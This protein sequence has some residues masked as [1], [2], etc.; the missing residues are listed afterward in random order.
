MKE[1]AEIISVRFLPLSGEFEA[2][3]AVR[4]S[5]GFE[6]GQIVAASK[7]LAR[8]VEMISPARPTNL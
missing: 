1:T 5:D 7:S 4:N 2:T 3:V 8:L 6:T